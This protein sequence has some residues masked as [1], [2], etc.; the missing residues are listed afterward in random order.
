MILVHYYITEMKKYNNANFAIPAEP[1]NNVLF[2]QAISYV[3]RHRLRNNS[4]NME[5]KGITEK[6]GE[7]MVS[8]YSEKKMHR[9]S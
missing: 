1:V 5:V 8:N 2:L 6:S 4:Q 9:S 3:E 7:N